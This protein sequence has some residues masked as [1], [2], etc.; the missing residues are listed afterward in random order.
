MDYRK[1]RD[2]VAQ[3][4][5]QLSKRQEQIGEE[6]A[7]L[8]SER[9]Q[10]KRE[11]IGLE[12]IIEGLEFAEGD[13]PIEAEPIGFT[14][15]I[16]QILRNTSIPLVPTQIRDALQASGVQASS[17]KTLL[18]NVHTVLTRID[19]ELEKATTRDGK[20][21]YAA[22]RTLAD[23][24]RATGE[25]RGLDTLLPLPSTNYAATRRKRRN[26]N[27]VI[28]TAERTQQISGGT[29]KN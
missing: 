24:A 23:I 25:R 6:I 2:D 9:E 10:V 7:K 27:E 20:I 17:P 19:N 15:R 4:Q 3:R 26:S 8:L 14:D 11:M 1:T 21:G 28:A 5:E 29:K 13:F 18:I 22:K 12:Q 16:R